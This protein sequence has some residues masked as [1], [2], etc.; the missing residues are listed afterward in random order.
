VSVTFDLAGLNSAL[1]PL[2]QACGWK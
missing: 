2:Q 1:K